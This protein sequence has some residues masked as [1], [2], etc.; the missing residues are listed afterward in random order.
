MKNTIPAR[1]AEIALT[2]GKLFTTDEAL[3]VEMS[4]NL[5]EN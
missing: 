3:K 2:T 1:E 4:Q 5:S